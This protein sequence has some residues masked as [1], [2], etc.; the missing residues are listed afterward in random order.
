[1]IEENF[2]TY[3]SLRLMDAVWFKIFDNIKI[4]SM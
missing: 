1:M 2:F 3:L 4:Y